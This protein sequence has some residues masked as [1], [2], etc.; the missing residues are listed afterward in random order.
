MSLMR[1]LSLSALT[2]M[3]A[4]CGEPS[5]PDL[6]PYAGQPRE[7]TAEESELAPQAS[8]DEIALRPTDLKAREVC[9]AV[10]GEF[11]TLLDPG[12]AFAARGGDGRV[13]VGWNYDGA[14]EQHVIYTPDVPLDDRL[15]Y[16]LAVG[17][18]QRWNMERDAPNRDLTG[19][20]RKRDG[21]LC[22]LQT[23]ASIIEPLINAWRTLEPALGNTSD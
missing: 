15:P 9:N 4:A 5:E 16:D 20:D 1:C 21:G 19:A 23:E 10:D 22:V 18:F 13:Y 6:S 8:E 17:D 7:Q 3:V 12:T 14:R 2:L 11:A